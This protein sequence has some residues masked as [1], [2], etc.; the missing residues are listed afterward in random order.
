VSGTV[1]RLPWQM[2]TFSYLDIVLKEM[3]HTD[4]RIPG[5]QAL[6]SY[7]MCWFTFSEKIIISY[8]HPLLPFSFPVALSYLRL[9]SS[10]QVY[11]FLT[12]HLIIIHFILHS[13]FLYSKCCIYTSRKMWKYVHMLLS[14]L[15]RQFENQRLHH[16]HRLW[17][18][19]CHFRA[20][21]HRVEGCA[22]TVALP[23]VIMPS[24][25]LQ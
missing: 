22:A 20:C 24:K 19:Q 10:F 14:D 5:H 15:L 12:D 17:G 6:N 18:A 7:S 21:H 2:W 25:C 16:E 3:G 11:S 4:I 9:L 13:T 1:T 23:F 8:L